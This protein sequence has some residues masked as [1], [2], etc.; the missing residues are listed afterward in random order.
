MRIAMYFAATLA[1]AFAGAAQA[2]AA[3]E[4]AKAVLDEA[5]LFDGHN[6]LPWAIR[7][8][9]VAKGDLD[10]YDLA[11]RAPEK[12]Q[13][14]IPRLRAGRVGAQF[15]SVYTPPEAPGGHARTQLEQIDLMRRIIARYPDTFELCATAADIRKA[16]AAGRIGG[17]LGIEGGHTIEDSP[18]ALRAYYDL[19]VRYMTLTHNRHTNWADAGLE[20]PPRFGG[21]N[22]FGEQVVAE[23][24]R[25]GMLVDLSH[26]SPDTMRDAL[27][28]SQAPV[29]FSHAAARGKTEI[30]RNVPDD[31]LDLVGANGGVVMVTFVAGFVSQDAADALL[32]FIQQYMAQAT[33]KGDEERRAIYKELRA[34]LVMPKVTV[35]D[36]ADHIEYIRDRIGVDHVGIGGDY[37]GNTDWPEGM[38]DVTGYPLLFA[39]LIRRGWS[40]GDLQK[41]AGEN[42]L[43]A[44]TQAEAV[45]RRLQQ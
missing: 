13:T 29:I 5:I 37:D 1:L 26:T 34:K 38:E 32:P 20:D 23:M 7:E 21:L 40:D 8:H 18:G 4:H 45:A 28:A 44:L 14:D 27:R 41:L 42:V 2:D 24:N 25:L 30:P 9:E 33:G 16:K 12:G 10:K 11:T 43:R 35:G 22:A 31:V 36:V 6:D 39:E 3:L 17:M 15:W 19:G